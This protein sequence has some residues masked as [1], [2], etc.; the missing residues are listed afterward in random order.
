MNPELRGSSRRRICQTEDLLCEKQEVWNCTR[1]YRSF[2]LEKCS[3]GQ[4]SG[5]LLANEEY[6]QH[7]NCPKDV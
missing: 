2:L 1:C 7:G 5:D 4:R 6:Q 3:A